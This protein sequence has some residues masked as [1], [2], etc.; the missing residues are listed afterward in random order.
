MPRSL[1]L[2]LV[3]A[4]FVSCTAR[5]DDAENRDCAAGAEESCAVAAGASNAAVGKNDGHTKQHSKTK[6][7]SANIMLSERPAP[8]GPTVPNL[9]GPS[10]WPDRNAA[11]QLYAELMAQVETAKSPSIS[12][13]LALA[14]CHAQ[15]RS[16]E[17]WRQ[18]AAAELQ[19]P[20]PSFF[21]FIRAHLVAA[22]LEGEPEWWEQGD[23]G[24]DDPHQ[25]PT[26]LALVQ[27]R[28]R[29]WFEDGEYVHLKRELMQN[30]KSTESEALLNMG[31][32][33]LNTLAPMLVA[34]KVSGRHEMPP[35]TYAGG[36]DSPPPLWQAPDKLPGEMRALFA[37][38]L[39]V[40]NL[41]DEGAVT[42]G[43]NAKM[44]QQAIGN[45][46]TF[47]KSPR[48]VDTETGKRHTPSR[49]ND[50]FWSEQRGKIDVPEVRGIMR[51][52]KAACSRYL[53]EWN[54]PPAMATDDSELNGIRQAWFSI[55]SNGSDHTTHVHY[56]SRLAA[57]YYPQVR[58]GDSRLVFEDPRG[59]HY[60]DQTAQDCDS[61]KVEGCSPVPFPFAP[62]AGNRH[63]HA[64]REGDLVIFPGWLYHSVEA[65]P[66]D[67]EGYRVSLSFNLDGYWENSVP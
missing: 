46:E 23:G 14:V 40:V 27:K 51:H 24:A 25:Q 56:D 65:T 7:P 4:A 17:A 43:F 41:V 64:P 3:V 38:P 58:D 13:L 61:A 48:A 49:L 55:H 63:Y 34:W 30:F 33:M 8:D 22:L 50:L 53:S 20:S 44:A 10:D 28:A 6:A 45:F 9:A 18:L 31:D 52:I 5:G 36:L 15:P 1:L 11:S 57:V 59:A 32:G 29:E 19:L 67:L 21:S 42:P 39:Y 47:L 54:L 16:H 35:L 2:V 12:K 62:F 60:N 26:E 37:T 66:V